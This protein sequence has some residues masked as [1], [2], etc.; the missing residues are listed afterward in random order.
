M[1][2]KFP[3]EAGW[4]IIQLTKGANPVSSLHP[5]LPTA[6]WHH[7]VTLQEMLRSW[8]GFLRVFEAP[9]PSPCLRDS[10]LWFSPEPSCPGLLPWGKALRSKAGSFLQAEVTTRDVTKPST[11]ASSL[12][13]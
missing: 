11:L 7:G 6:F 10:I 8:E 1:W 9:L 5:L 13:P 3:L 4:N 2:D 12:S